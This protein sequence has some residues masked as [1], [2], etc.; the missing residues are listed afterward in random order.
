MKVLLH[1]KIHKLFE[2]TGANSE[3]MKEMEKKG[4]SGVPAVEG[5]TVRYVDKLVGG[6]STIPGTTYHDFKN[7]SYRT[8]LD[9]L[10][11]PLDTLK[12]GMK[13]RNY[14]GAYNKIA[15]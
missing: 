12:G 7:I 5:I 9:P 3:I 1:E 4:K 13:A 14:A 10:E 11:L 8:G 2:T 6:S 15:A